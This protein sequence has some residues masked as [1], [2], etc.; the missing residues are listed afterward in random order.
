[1]IVIISCNLPT[2]DLKNK[3]MSVETRKCLHI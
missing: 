1:V 3:T 2:S